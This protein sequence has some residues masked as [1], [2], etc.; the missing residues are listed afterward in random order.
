MAFN[1]GLTTLMCICLCAWHCLQRVSVVGEFEMMAMAIR[2]S[3]AFDFEH[4]GVV[5]S[6]DVLGQR[7]NRRIDPM[8]KI[9]KYMKDTGLR[10]TELFRTFDKTVSNRLRTDTFVDR[11]NV[12]TIHIVNY[13]PR[14]LLRIKIPLTYVQLSCTIND[15][16]MY[17][18]CIWTQ[19]D[20]THIDCFNI[21]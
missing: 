21:K 12:R 1:C 3:R 14:Q 20:A 9:M 11:L 7:Q 16:Y 15:E 4:G 19:D 8:E 13:S 2:Q 18:Y 6:H 17:M 5:N 10:T